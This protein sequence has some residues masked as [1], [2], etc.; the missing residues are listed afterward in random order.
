MSENN[1]FNPMRWNCKEDGCYNIHQRP[2]IEVFADCFPG[3]INFGDIDQQIVEINGRALITE[4]KHPK[5]IFPTGQRIMY[6]RLSKTWVIYVATLTITD[7]IKMDVSAMGWYIGGKFNGWKAMDL[8]GAREKFRRWS[9]LVASLSAI[10]MRAPLP[11]E[12]LFPGQKLV[13]NLEDNEHLFSS[14]RRDVSP[15]ESQDP[16]HQ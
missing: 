9:E 3:L 14:F 8:D 12:R 2:K 6:E 4:Y 1:G 10:S 16:W 15:D 13:A 11:T 5:A 7:A